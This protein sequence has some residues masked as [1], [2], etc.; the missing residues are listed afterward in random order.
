MRKTIPVLLALCLPAALFAQDGWRLR[1][2]AG[3]GGSFGFSAY[4]LRAMD[5]AGGGAGAASRLEFP[6]TTLATEVRLWAEHGREGRRDWVLFA[7]AEI[8]LLDPAG[9]MR[10]Y[11]WYTQAGFPDMPFSYTESPALMDSFQAAV[12]VDRLISRWG[13]VELY[14]CLGY[15]YR[16]IHQE[17]H[18]YTGWQYVWNNPPGAF[19]LTYGSGNVHALTYRIDYHL[20]S[21]GFAARL[22]P[23]PR[24]GLAL[25]AA[26]LLPYARDVDDHLLRFKR[27]VGQ[28]F[29]YGY[30]AEL[31]LLYLLPG[32]GRRFRPYLALRGG[33]SG[34]AVPGTQT[35]TWY[36]D[37]PATPDHVEQ[38]GDQ[39]GGIYH[40]ISSTQGGV[41]LTA[42]V[43][44]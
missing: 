36:G 27:S 38:P 11:D 4:D 14:A 18:S 34:L 8:G 22:E 30:Q 44:F 16:Y 33:L 13:P 32:G 20:P 29:G 2:D 7:G 1:A 5:P 41:L 3:A 28:G 43:I 21:A 37:D 24:L 15:R 23:F 10:D 35:Q 40:F 26:L 25:S 9:S 6:L 12:R 31:E 19:E 42:G 17:I 39:A